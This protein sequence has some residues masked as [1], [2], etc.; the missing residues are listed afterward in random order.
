MGPGRWWFPRFQC[1]RD[2]VF[3]AC[4]HGFDAVDR[5][6]ATQANLLVVA[7]VDIEAPSSSS[8]MPFVVS[9]PSRIMA[10]HNQRVHHPVASSSP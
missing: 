1:R 10:L 6:V 8:E 4:L 9:F 5:A 7:H 3:A 2:A